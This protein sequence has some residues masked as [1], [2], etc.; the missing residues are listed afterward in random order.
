ME[1][2][3][4]KRWWLLT[5][6]RQQWIE[7]DDNYY[8]HA[9]PFEKSEPFWG[10]SDELLRHIQ[11]HW[12]TKKELTLLKR[13]WQSYQKIALAVK[14]G[15][16]MPWRWRGTFKEQK[17]PASYS[18]GWK[19]VLRGYNPHLAW[20]HQE[21]IEHLTP[22][23]KKSAPWLKHQ[24]LVDVRNAKICLSFE[25]KHEAD[26]EENDWTRTLRVSCLDQDGCN[27]H[28][29]AKSVIKKV[30]MLIADL[31]SNI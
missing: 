15:K 28:T 25:G 7:V 10:T 1:K 16:Q 24:I 12:F 31:Q 3:Q 8:N 4:I 23:E 2:N 22:E 18:I 13:G 20:Y 17:E 21:H 29:M 11:K 19:Y 14:G 26:R 5:T 6:E 30:G 9:R 27:N